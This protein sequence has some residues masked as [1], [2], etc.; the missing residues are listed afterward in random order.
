MVALSVALAEEVAEKKTEK[1]WAYGTGLGYNNGYSGLGNSVYS[2]YNQPYN[3]LGTQIIAHSAEKKIRFSCTW[4]HSD[5]RRHF[6]TFVWN[7]VCVCALFPLTVKVWDQFLD[8]ISIALCSEVPFW[9]K[10]NGW[11]LNTMQIGLT[12]YNLI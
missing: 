10:K 6:T 1:R 11:C 7:I 3:Q 2:G 12:I 4:N 8:Y 9:K 5:N